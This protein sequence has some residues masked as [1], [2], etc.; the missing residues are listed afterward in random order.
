MKG[1]MKVNKIKHCTEKFPA[2]LHKN[3]RELVNYGAREYNTSDAYILKEKHGKEI[4][5][6]HI[7]YIDFKN[8]MNWYGTGLM[9]RGHKG[10]RI[11]VMGNNCY[12]WALTYFTT[13]AGLGICV[14][15]DKA[16][17]YDELESSLARSYTDVLVFDKAHAD[18]VEQLKKSDKIKVTDYIC[19]DKLEGYP[20]VEEIM[21]E[22]KKEL[23]NGNDKY[24]SLPIDEFA[25]TIILFTSGTTSMAKAVKLSQ[26][27][28]LTNTY[29][30]L[31]VEDIQHGDRTMA[32]LPYHHTFGS[33]GQVVMQAAG[34]TTTYCD[35][36]KYVQKNIVE[37]K[38]TLF[39][40]VPILIETIYKKI[41][42]QVKKQGLEKKVKRGMKLCNALMKVGIDVR[43][44]VFKDI[45]NQLGGELRFIISGASALNP[46]AHKGFMT[47]GIDTVQGYGL[48]ETAP[49]LTA[50]TLVNH[51]IG[52]IGRALPGLE[53]DVF[54]PTVEGIGEL[55]AKGPNVMSGYYENQE[56]TDRVIVDGWFHT[57]DLVSVDKDGYVYIRGRKKNVIVLKNGKNVYPE[58]LE[59][60]INELP[61]VEE[62]MV[63]GEPRYNDGNQNDLA[64][65]AKIVYKPDY[66][67]EHLNATDPEEIK[68]IIDAD[69]DKINDNVPIYKRML[70]VTVTDQPMIKTTTG[71]VK[72][73]E[74]IKKQ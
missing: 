20:S 47:F 26:Y 64:V 46:E 56:E 65:C 66:M 29:A 48:T 5:Y 58:E 53:L 59:V 4:S 42:I 39:I 45:L 36:L 15:L 72:R 55:I 61:Y 37:Y 62:S 21:E 74:E 16:L 43:R 6:R 30:M 11:A 60:L 49:V 22:G 9:V 32:F 3:I 57:G 63:Y 8:H 1:K 51:R 50:E 2:V 19:M 18:A 34:V 23:E 13:L 12:Q 28:I 54:E 25:T 31:K 35:G 67:K 52:S 68:K 10:K 27:N 24:L 14:P 41:M 38:I 70:R 44:K 71:K 69:I 33:T 17:P 7:T 40:C 73:H